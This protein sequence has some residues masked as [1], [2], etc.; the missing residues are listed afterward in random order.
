MVFQCIVVFIE[1]V[2]G[3]IF[4]IKSVEMFSETVFMLIAA[5]VQEC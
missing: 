1:V 2:H 3:L 4:P 5:T